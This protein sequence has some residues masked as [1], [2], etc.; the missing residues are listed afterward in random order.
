MTDLD[1]DFPET[2]A[3]LA[4]EVDEQLFTRGAQIALVVDGDLVLSEALGDDGLGRPVTTE[5]VF[6][7]YCTI[8]PV[9]SLAVARMVDDGRLDLDAPLS[10]HLPDFASVA[11]GAV[12]LRDLLSHAAGLHHPTAVEVE[13]I[14]P[15]R[16]DEFFRQV[17]R[18]AGWRVGTDVAYSERFAWQLVGVLL[19]RV[20][21]E[22]LREH[23]RSS[24]L[25][26]L[27]LGDTWIGMTDAEYD[28]VL[29]RLGVN[30]D[31]RT[32]KSY[33]LLLERGRRM[34]TEVNCAHGG[35]TTAT[36]LAWFYASILEGLAGAGPAAAVLPSAATLRTFTS[37]V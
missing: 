26:P 3:I 13:L 9:A 24:V 6:R 8:K 21:G 5:T 32:H 10:E 14:S 33:P 16:R 12:A 22:P 15:D 20:S 31:M 23:L 28:D 34:C 1:T 29:P 25:D 35:Y 2:L 7:V 4:S 11:D 18:P 37:P 19:E 27:D 36:D 17:T 30:H